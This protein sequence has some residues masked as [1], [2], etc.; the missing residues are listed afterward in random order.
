MGKTKKKDKSAEMFRLVE[1]I[2]ENTELGIFQFKF[3]SSLNWKT[4]VPRRLDNRLR[5]EVA[6][7]DSE[8]IFRN[9]EKTIWGGAY[10]KFNGLSLNTS[11]ERNR[12]E[13]EKV[14][15]TEKNEVLNPKETFPIVHLKEYDIAKKNIYYIQSKRTTKSENQKS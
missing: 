13:S 15:S 4:R 14:S 1:E 5:N 11:T 9:N 6:S 8:L 3:D 2:H 7:I 10:F 12:Q